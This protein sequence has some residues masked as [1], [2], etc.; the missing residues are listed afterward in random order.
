MCMARRIGFGLRSKRRPTG[1]EALT[2]ARTMFTRKAS[3]GGAFHSGDD[4]GQYLGRGSCCFENYCGKR[5]KRPR[6]WNEGEEPPWPSG[7]FTMR[8]DCHTANVTIWF[9]TGL[10]VRMSVVRFRPYL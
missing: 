7:G 2:G 10:K 3:S 6:R 9:M 5:Q 1:R 4:A 8:H